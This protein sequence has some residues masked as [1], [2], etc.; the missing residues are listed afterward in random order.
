MRRYIQWGQGD[1]DWIVA[2]AARKPWQK[3]RKKEMKYERV[4][5]RNEETNKKETQ[6]EKKK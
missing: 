5:L 2:I 4:D 3:E 6:K 1:R